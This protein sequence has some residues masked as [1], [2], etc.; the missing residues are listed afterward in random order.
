MSSRAKFIVGLI[1]FTIFQRLLPY[2]VT[3][4]DVNQ[5]PSIIFYPWSFM[6]LTAVCMYLGAHIHSRRSS[7]GL[8]LL[9]LL[10]SDLSIWFATGKF[11]SAFPP[12][13][14]AE[15]VAYPLI[16]MLGIGLN[17][18][19]WPSRMVSAFGRGI[20]AEIAFFAISN[21]AYFLTQTAHS[22]DVAGLIACYV[23]A[24]PFANKAFVSTAIYSVL[25]F[26]PIAVR[27]A[28]ESP[29]VSDEPVL[30]PALTR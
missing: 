6:P 8:A 16:V 1:A 4:P 10:L 27:A 24:I 2:L 5:N 3:N 19:A 23:D 29:T 15:Y 7:I 26:S 18:N 9:M 30:E 11:A 28:G 12:D 13:R 17:Q 25:L 14:C 20:V 22:P 21:F